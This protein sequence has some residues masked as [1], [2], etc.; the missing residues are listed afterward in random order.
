MRA[1][2]SRIAEQ[3]GILEQCKA[4][5]DDLL[6]IK[7]IVPDKSDDGI[8]FDLNGFLSNIY[9]VMTHW[10]ADSD[11]ACKIYADML[12]CL[13]TE[14]KD[15][16][17]DIGT[18]FVNTYGALSGTR[19]DMDGI[20]KKGETE[21]LK[22]T[23]YVVDSLECALY[24]LWDSGDFDEAIIK[25]A[26]MGGDADTIAAICGGLA[27]ALYGSGI[28]SMYP[29]SSSLRVSRASLSSS[30]W[31]IIDRSAFLRYL[32]MSISFPLTCH[33]QAG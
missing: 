30:I 4:F 12:H 18:L 22:P 28:F 20:Q 24:A 25:A 7:D 32:F 31:S 8:P 26:N 5:E 14:A 23:G 2:D 16:N 6:K 15:G 21:S 3:F 29:S 19:Y 13:M 33:H 10:D 1:S 11:E 27:G 17:Q 9:Y